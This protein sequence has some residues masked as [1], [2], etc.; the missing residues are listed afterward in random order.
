MDQE[1]GC[2]EYQLSDLANDHIEL[3]VP[4]SGFSVGIYRAKP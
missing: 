4:L 2:S 1:T 3:H